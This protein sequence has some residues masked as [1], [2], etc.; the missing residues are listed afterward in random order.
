MITSGVGNSAVAGAVPVAGGASLERLEG[1]EIQSKQSSGIGEG[2]QDQNNKYGDVWN[3]VQAK[4]GKKP[5]KAKEIKKTLGK[6]D[7]MNLMINQM[8]NQDPTKPFDAEQM[9]A[10]LAQFASVEQLTNMNQSI[11][12]M[13]ANSQP[14]E[15]MTMT[16]M[17]GKQ[18]TVDRNRIIHVEN[19]SSP[20]SFSVPERAKKLKVTLLSEVGEPIYTHELNDIDAGEHTISWDG[21]KPNSL[22][23]KSGQYIMR[24]E[25][26]G[27]DNRP[28]NMDTRAKANVVGVAFEGSEAVL[29]IGDAKHQEK[30]PMKNI[31][32]IEEASSL[33][34]PSA[35][36]IHPEQSQVKASQ[37]ETS[38]DE[39][40]K[41]SST[42]ALP[43]NSG[44][45]SMNQIKS[46]PANNFFAFT[47]GEGSHSLNKENEQSLIPV[48]NVVDQNLEKGGIT[49]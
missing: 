29:L 36:T 47:P 2:P 45:Q 23:A 28:L 24:F 11:N 42:Q 16:H 35:R 15:R 34:L 48:K 3:Q 18:V 13:A 22:P 31:I 8:K 40:E 10:Q 43:A 9:A 49:Q 44:I 1:L 37:A 6:D 33:P 7:F 41:S 32:R 4:Y 46:E 26:V 19:E 20:L 27:V 5:E 12:R 30:V 38:Q 21:K 17:I 25:G 14:L 39:L